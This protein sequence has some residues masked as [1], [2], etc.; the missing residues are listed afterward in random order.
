MAEE[1]E[2]EKQISHN[3]AAMRDRIASAAKKSGRQSKDVTLVAVTKYV[4]AALTRAV[5]A[6]GCVDLGESRPQDLWKKALDLQA[7]T[8][9]WHMIGHLQRNKV[10]RTIAVTS[11]IHSVDSPRLLQEIQQQAVERNLNVRVLL[12]INISGDAAKHGFTADGVTAEL[13]SLEKYPNVIVC[14]L[15]GMSGLESDTVQARCEFAS[16]RELRDKLNQHYPQLTSLRELSMG[17]SDDYEI[18]IEEG[19]TIVRVGSR[20]FEGI[21]S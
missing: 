18:A 7:E 3:V 1:S 17:M 21:E 4:D 11:L 14:G 19:A 5:A 16:L 12:E 9:R 6:A 8:V 15:M 20:L 10:A 13:D 2:I